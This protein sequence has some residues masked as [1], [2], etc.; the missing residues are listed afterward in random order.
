MKK[1]YLLAFASMFAAATTAQ[2]TLKIKNPMKR[3]GTHNEKVGNP[4]SVNQVAGN[5]VCNTQYVAG[6]SMT[7]N[8]TLTLTNLDEEYV[9]LLTITF[10]AGITPTNAIDP[11]P[12]TQNGGQ[13]PEALNPIAGQVV[14][15]G[16]ND[17]TYGG[18]ESPT[19]T[20]SPISYNFTVDVTVTAGLTGNQTANFV[21]DGD[22]YG[23]SPGALTSS[24]IIYPA[25]A[26]IIDLRTD[27]V[28]PLN[29]TALNVCNYGMDTLVAQVTNVGN[30]TESN[31]TAY[32][33]VNGVMQPSTVV[34]G[35]LAPGDSTYVFWLPAY[36]FSPSN[37]YTVKAWTAVPS[38][39]S[40][41]NDTA[42]LDFVNSQSVPL[43]SQNFT[44]GAE[45]GYEFES[46]NTLGGYVSGDGYIFGP[47]QLTFNTGAQ[48]LFYTVPNTATAGAHEAMVIL[49]CVDVTLGETYR[50]SFYKRINGTAASANGQSGVF[51]GLANDPS[52][53]TTTLKAYT[54]ITPYATWI[55][56][57]VD[58]IATA[59]ETRYFALGGTGSVV[60]G[61]SQINV[62]YDDINIMKLIT[63]GVNSASATNELS[64]FPNPTTGIV[65][66]TIASKEALVAVYN[67]MGEE[68]MNAKIFMGNNTVDL[69]NL[70]A[71]TYFV[72]VTENEKVSTQKINL[73]R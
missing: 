61:T 72:R 6:T 39:I 37:I 15:W 27:F 20:G 68:V 66:V 45:P 53:M 67:V 19:P 59:T 60:S 58:Y 17:N 47:S 4:V 63:I 12:G 7:L 33:S 57:S 10:P 5:I 13:T 32:A 8:M 9:D 29:L 1:I 23:P 18:I 11:F 70:S 38:D 51:T 43:T 21:A 2:T 71:G 36:D 31:F 52:A 73:T 44:N 42:S 26:S 34:P 62:R 40:A 14:S 25:G 46:L 30:T 64:I 69:A 28:Q 3:S 56:D 49:P 16:D 24:F 22:G 54:A 65:N 48:A 41:T 50:I 55:K 35:P